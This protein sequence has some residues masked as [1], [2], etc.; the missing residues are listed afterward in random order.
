MAEPKTTEPKAGGKTP[1]H[2]TVLI[3]RDERVGKKDFKPGDTPKL[4]YAEAQRLI[5]GGGADGDSGAIR[6]AQAQRKQAA[7][8]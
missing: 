5:K 1:S 2:L 6:A 3:L 8:G 7:Q 4:S